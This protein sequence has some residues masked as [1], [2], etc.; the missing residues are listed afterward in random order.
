MGQI[1]NRCGLAIRSLAEEEAAIMPPNDDPF[2]P[3][4]SNRELRKS[5]LDD[6]DIS[7]VITSQP[8]ESTVT[9]QSSCTKALWRNRDLLTMKDGVLLTNVTGL[10][11]PTTYN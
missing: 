11:I 5:Q 7:P 1:R 10:I 8:S 3:R 4:Y 6:N 9:L 2:F